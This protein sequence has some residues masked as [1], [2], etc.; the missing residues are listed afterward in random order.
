V[1]VFV[2][3]YFVYSRGTPLE[4]PLY[5]LQIGEK[6]LNVQIAATPDQWHKGLS[7]RQ[8]LAG[9]EGMLFVFDEPQVLNFSTRDTYVPLGLAFI[10]DNCI[11][12][13]VMK[14]DITAYN[15]YSSSQ[16]ARAALE[17]PLGWFENNANVTGWA[18]KIPELSCPN[19]W[20]TCCMP[21]SI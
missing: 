3:S 14:M 1:S 7:F 17:A 11:I 12:Q 21:Q 4:L 19:N 2:V 10:A 13:E 16:P 20:Q 18:L 9:D 8:E 15:K 6:M 5:R